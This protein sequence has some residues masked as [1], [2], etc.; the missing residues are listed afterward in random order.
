MR[1]PPTQEKQ[2]HFLFQR[3]CLN[4]FP[5][6]NICITI[7]IPSKWVVFNQR[8]LMVPPQEGFS[9]EHHMNIIVPYLSPII[10]ALVR[11]RNSGIGCSRKLGSKVRINGL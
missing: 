3:K 7:V 5:L 10:A 6:E 11:R 2:W 1:L 4:F 9:I 8:N